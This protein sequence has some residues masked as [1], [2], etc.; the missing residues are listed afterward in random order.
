MGVVEPR[1]KRCGAAMWPLLNILRSQLVS[2][3]NSYR[4][5]GIRTL[6]NSVGLNQRIHLIYMYVCK[7]ACTVV[8]DKTWR[9]LSGKLA[10]RAY[11]R[12]H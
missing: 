7:W 1:S 8:P 2:V 6:L 12:T 4:V 11:G 5:D 3:K 10:G 9:H